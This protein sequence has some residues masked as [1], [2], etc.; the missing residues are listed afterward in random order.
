MI[1]NV[2]FWVKNRY[3]GVMKLK[4]LL[5]EQIKRL[6]KARGLTQE[7]LA[8][9]IEIAPRNLS[10]IEVGECF[11][12]AETLEKIISALNVTAEELF[13]YEHIRDE[14]ELLADIYTYL[15]TIKTNKQQLEK[16][17]RA[18]KFVSIN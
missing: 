12:T 5:G 14:K 9:I 4:K 15:D 1:L 16:V 10:R 13:A 18:I 6:R 17:Y 7:Q 8:E 11:V 3:R 2:C